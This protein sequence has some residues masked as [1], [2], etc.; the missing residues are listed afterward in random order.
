MSTAGNIQA[1]ARAGNGGGILRLKIQESYYLERIRDYGLHSARAVGWTDYLQVMLFEKISRLFAGRERGMRYT[2]LDVGAGLGDF[3][4]Y[5]HDHGYA[6]IEYHGVDVVPEMAAAARRK[7]P[8]LDVRVADFASP[9]FSGEYDYTVC[10]GALNIITERSAGDYERFVRN[11]IR[12]MYGVSRAGCAFNLLCHE[13]KDFFPDDR[14]FYYARRD[15]IH[16]SCAGFCD[17]VSVDYQEHE[18]T[19]TVTLRK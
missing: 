8:G 16:D 10:S 17:T 4:R 19:F 2:L 7:Y 5:L 12:K 13:A 9:A 11:F 15:E 18:F 3:S 14:C 6:D 1:G